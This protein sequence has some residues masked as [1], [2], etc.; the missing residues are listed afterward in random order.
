MILEWMREGMRLKRENDWDNDIGVNERGNEIEKREWVRE[1]YWSEWE[2]EWDWKERMIERMIL[3]WMREG[4]R[5]KREN[6]W[7]NDNGVNKRA[8][9]IKRGIVTDTNLSF[10][11]L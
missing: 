10:L 5:L 9:E 3:V 7:E 4:M 2:R 11:I 1:W 6:K 8:D